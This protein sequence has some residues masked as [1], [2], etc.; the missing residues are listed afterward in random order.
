MPRPPSK[1]SACCGRR[2]WK[3]S[4]R[5]KARCKRSS[6]VSAPAV[7]LI[8]AGMIAHDQ[9]LPSL[10]H[11]Q[12]QGL[13]GEISVCA[14]R[15]GSLKKLAGASIFRRAF[16]GQSFRPYPDFSV[17]PD[18]PHPNLFR[19]VIGRMEAGGIAVVAVPDPLHLE[20]IMA[21]LRAGLH[22]CSVKPLVL[23]ARESAVIEQE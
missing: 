4:Q 23:T 14:S 13:I 16:P 6:E 2:W 18:E 12:R 1:A 15:S 7:V 19:E 17:D 21:A 11:L 22:V 8:G 10:Y 9:I 3:P 5:D 20:V